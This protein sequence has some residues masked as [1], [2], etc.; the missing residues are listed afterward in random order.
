MYFGKRRSPFHDCI[1]SWEKN[2]IEIA[3]EIARFQNAKGFAIDL[4]EFLGSQA[5]YLHSLMALSQ[6]DCIN[7]S[8]ERSERL[9]NVQ[10]ALEALRNVINSNPGKFLVTRS[11]TSGFTCRGKLVRVYD[12]TRQVFLV[13]CLVEK[14]ASWLLISRTGKRGT[15]ATRPVR[16]GGAKPFC[17]LL[18][19]FLPW[20]RAASVI[21]PPVSP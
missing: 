2:V 14:L 1:P 21:V 8:S 5:Q 19:R 20:I 17:T 15:P 9:H 4:L 12:N 3:Y 11:C 18:H 7:T 16:L 13:R 10:M 6:Q